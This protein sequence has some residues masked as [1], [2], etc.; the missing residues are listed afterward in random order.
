MFHAFGQ[1]TLPVFLQSA[2]AECG[3]ACVGMVAQHYGYISDMSALRRRFPITLKGVSALNLLSIGAEIGLTGRGVKCELEQ[4]TALKLPVILHWDL[5]HFVVLSS[6]RGDKYEILDPAKGRMTMTLDAIS[7]H[8]TGVALELEPSPHFE[9]LN[10]RAKLDLGDLLS[11]NL[12]GEGNLYQA[13]LFSVLVQVFVL[14]APIFMQLVIDDAI[15]RQDTNLIWVLG[16]AFLLLKSLEVVSD[17]VRRFIFQLISIALSFDLKSRVFHHL[18]RLPLFYFHGRSTG[19]IQQRFLS[20]T[21]ISQFVVDGLIEALVDG[22]FAIG[23]LIVLFLYDVRLAVIVT[24]FLVLYG[25]VRLALFPRARRLQTEQQINQAKEADTFLE[26]LTG[27]QTIKLSGVEIERETLWR[28]KAT[29]T[30]NSDIRAGNMSIVYATT[31]QG[32]I[33]ISQITVVLV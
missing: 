18:L 30:A 21:V 25:A 32:I 15:V 7:Q 6:F 28:N 11:W 29:E 4:L 24:A 20:L 22:V 5:N 8:F 19:D 14:S 10:E 3:L 16:L 23:I 1:R 13:I 31:G 33:A 26:T 17:L 12:G 2:S 9:Q 27:M